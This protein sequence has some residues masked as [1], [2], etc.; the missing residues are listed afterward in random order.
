LINA[1]YFEGHKNRR[2]NKVLKKE[3]G[4][5]NF[6]IRDIHFLK[7]WSQILYLKEIHMNHAEVI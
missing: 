1:E 3:S 6:R 7:G 5:M 2:A 4:R